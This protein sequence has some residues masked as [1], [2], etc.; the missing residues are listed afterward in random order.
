MRRLIAPALFACCLIA[1][2]EEKTPNYTF[3]YDYPAQAGAIAPL[4]AYLD[5]EKA[6][7]RAKVAAESAGDR[8][9]AKAG[10]YDFRPYDV[11]TGW[12]VVTD[13]PRFLS[14]SG[15]T[16]SYT[17]GA[18]GN[19]Q[20]FALVWDKAA[21]QR[22]QPIALFTSAAAVE[23]AIKPDFCAALNK[24]REEKR[25]EPVKANSTDS[26]ETCPPLKD[27]T[28]LLGSTDRRAIDRI[29]LIADAY[30]A[31]PYVEGQY[32]VTLP[33]TPALLAAVKPAYRAAFRA[34]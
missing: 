9:D 20:S 13:T 23:R 29:G 34:R 16:W 3:A 7:Q 5:G 6:K 18:H 24:E 27:L 26:F 15:S 8:R 21:R 28:L 31:G 17:G 11:E 2:A 32:E 25:G 4:K 33:V 22:L 14:L 10:G 12:Q 30:V 1:A 19:S